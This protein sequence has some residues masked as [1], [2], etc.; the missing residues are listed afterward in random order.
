MPLPY[1]MLQTWCKYRLLPKSLSN[2]PDEFVKFYQQGSPNS[3]KKLDHRLYQG[4]EP[5]REGFKRF[6]VISDTHNR[7]SIE[8]DIPDGDVL[9]HCGDATIRSFKKEFVS[10]NEWIGALPHPKKIVI[11]GNH[12]RFLELRPLNTFFNVFGASDREE[13]LEEFTNYTYIEDESINVHGYTIYGSPWTPVHLGGFQKQRGKSIRTKWDMIP[14]NTDILLT[15]GPPV[16]VGDLT[17]HGDYAGCVDLL[18]QIQ[19]RIK[20]LFHCFGHIH[21]G[22][23]VYTDTTTTY[24]NA[25][26]C[27]ISYKARQPAYVFDLPEKNNEDYD[28]EPPPYHLEA[29][30][31]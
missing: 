22:N 8:T 6:V 13:L 29:A 5:K 9:L 3:I 17:K 27:D 24:I 21:E 28:L 23:G 12:D 10:F 7:T 31:E 26:I 15:H 20:P 1:K 4:L 14:S 18:D 25:A 11:A 30:D 16:S 19:N 2:A